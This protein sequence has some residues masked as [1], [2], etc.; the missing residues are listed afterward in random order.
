[1]LFFARYGIVVRSTDNGPTAAQAGAA[2][3]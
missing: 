3:E 1:M 2:K